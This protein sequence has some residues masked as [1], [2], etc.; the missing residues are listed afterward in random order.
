MGVPSFDQPLVFQDR[1]P[2]LQQLDTI[3]LLPKVTVSPGGHE[4]T[5]QWAPVSGATEIELDRA[6]V[7]IGPNAGLTTGTLTTSKKGSVYELVVPAHT[8]VRSISLDTLRWVHTVDSESVKSALRTNSDLGNAVRITVA[9]PD[10][11][12]Q[13]VTR[14]AVPW[15]GPRNGVPG[16]FGGAQLSNGVI[17]FPE[18]SESRIQLGLVDQKA[19]EDWAAQSMELGSSV[20]ASIVTVPAEVSLGGPDGTELWAFPGDYADV[21]HANVSIVPQIRAAFEAAL[22]AGDPIEAKLTLVAANEASIGFRVDGPSGALI[23]R[24]DSVAAVIMEGDP[25][26]AALVAGGDAPLAAE[27]PASASAD[28]TITYAGIRLL[29]TIADKLPSPADVRG[30]VVRSEPRRRILPPQ[31]LNGVSIARIGVIGRA[32]EACEVSVQLVD[33]AADNAPL[34]P[35]GVVQLEAHDDIRTVW[36]EMPETDVCDSSVAISAKATRGRFFWCADGDTPLVRVAIHDPDPG[37]RPIDLGGVTVH[38]M[39]E[40]TAQLRGVTLPASAFRNEVQ[41]FES[42]LFVTIEMADLLLRYAR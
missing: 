7:S 6:A 35:P 12:N 41:S 26:P 20:S 40:E 1:G 21:P 14:F 10:T 4:V 17:S 36:I 37:G 38:S 39:A 34:G 24:F 15:V 23:R 32:P 5:L 2:E 18:M 22:R 30:F 8:R 3:P 29:E 33:T 11:Q 31:A 42:D 9:A 16:Q 19:P 25:A 28:I 27:I 13:M